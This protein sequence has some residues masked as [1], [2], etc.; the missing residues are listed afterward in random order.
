MWLFHMIKRQKHQ[1]KSV[2]RDITHKSNRSNTHTRF[3][4]IFFYCYYQLNSRFL[5]TQELITNNKRVARV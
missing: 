3:S 2:F 1:R 5:Q 4:G